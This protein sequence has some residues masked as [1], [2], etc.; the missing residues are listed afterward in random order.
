M[1]PGYGDDRLWTRPSPYTGGPFTV[2]ATAVAGAT[3]TCTITNASAPVPPVLS[4]VQVVKNFVGDPSPTTIFVDADGAAPFDASTS[5]A[6]SGASTLF[7]YPLS[8]NV[9]RGRDGRPNGLHGHDRLWNGACG[10]RRRSVRR[11]L[12]GDG[13][14]DPHLHDHEHGA[15]SADTYP[16]DSHPPDTDPAYTYPAYT[17]SAYPNPADSYPADSYP[18]DSS[19]ASG[20]SASGRDPGQGCESQPG[21]GWRDG[22]VHDHDPRR[23]RERRSP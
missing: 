20:A 8:T 7:T 1:P 23:Q 2:T 6:A 21:A 5:A 17:Y 11:H 12:A 13:W 4:T 3:L 16:A 14:C 22:A 15:C 9:D 19:Q 10:V 18:A